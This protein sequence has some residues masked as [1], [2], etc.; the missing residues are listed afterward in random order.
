MR[1]L[2]DIYNPQEFW[3]VRLTDGYIEEDPAITDNRTRTYNTGDADWNLIASVMREI[4]QQ[5]MDAT[6]DHVIIEYD[7]PEAHADRDVLVSWFGT[8]NPVVGDFG[9]DGDGR[10]RVWKTLQA[11]PN[12]LVPV[13]SSLRSQSRVFGRPK[14]HDIEA[15]LSAADETVW[16]YNENQLNWFESYRD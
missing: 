15:V 9:T 8:A 11:R 10:H 6:D 7:L 4:S 2:V 13:R 1:Q 5:L 3:F 16:T 12:A 14:A